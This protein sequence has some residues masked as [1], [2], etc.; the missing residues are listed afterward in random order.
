MNYLRDWN[1]V[2]RVAKSESVQALLVGFSSGELK[3]LSISRDQI[4]GD[5][6]T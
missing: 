3:I 4:A 6:P 2:L 1:K 5:Q